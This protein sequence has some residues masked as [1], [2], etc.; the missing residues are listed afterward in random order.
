MSQ[1]YEIDSLDVKILSALQEEARTPYLEIARKLIVSGGTIH[2][3]VDKMKEAGIIK[4]SNISL[5]LQ[6]TWL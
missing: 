1:E 4:G 3:R 5:D 2:Q 6:K